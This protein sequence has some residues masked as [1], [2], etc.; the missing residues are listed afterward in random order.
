MYVIYNNLHIN[1]LFYKI[2]LQFL[3]FAT[4]QQIIINKNTG[5]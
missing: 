1:N 5:M 4:A 3:T 2:I